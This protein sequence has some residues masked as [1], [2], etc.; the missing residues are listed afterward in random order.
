MVSIIIGA[1][2]SGQ[3][4][5][6]GTMATTIAKQTGLTV[7]NLSSDRRF[8]R[9]NGDPYGVSLSCFA[10]AGMS[11]RYVGPHCQTDDWYRFVAK[12]GSILTRRP[13][14]LVSKGVERWIRRE[15]ESSDPDDIKKI[16]DAGGFLI[17]CDDLDGN[18]E[19]YIFQKVA[20]EEFQ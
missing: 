17:M 1:V 13:E 14:L 8:I 7:G 15:D 5:L 12:T 19:V 18:P 9:L 16:P 11:L 10:P 4:S 20:P 6:C 2:V 3:I